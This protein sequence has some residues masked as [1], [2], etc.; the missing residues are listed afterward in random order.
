MLAGSK[1][2]KGSESPNS[3]SLAFV[4]WKTAPRASMKHPRQMQSTALQDLTVLLLSLAQVVREL[5][6][7]TSSQ[8][9]LGIGTRSSIGTAAVMLDGPRTE[10]QLL[11][12]PNEYVPSHHY[13][14][15]FLYLEILK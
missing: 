9:F 2:L 5:K 7:L 1:V 13:L 12:Q 14:T 15:H 11:E 8:A 6:S 3:V 4:S 10:A